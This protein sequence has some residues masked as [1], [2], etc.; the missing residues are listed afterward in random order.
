MKIN[1]DFFYPNNNHNNSNSRSSGKNTSSNMLRKQINKG[2]KF[3]NYLKINLL[4][5]TIPI[6]S[7]CT[8]YTWKFYRKTKKLIDDYLDSYIKRITKKLN[9]FRE[10]LEA[11]RIKNCNKNLSIELDFYSFIDINTCLEIVNLK[12][13]ISNRLVY[14]KNYELYTNK[15]QAIQGDVFEEYYCYFNEIKK[16]NRS[17]DSEVIRI[18]EEN[19]NIS[20]KKI[21]EKINDEKEFLLELNELIMAKDFYTREKYESEN[22]FSLYD[23]FNI[24]G[25][26]SLFSFLGFSKKKQQS[27]HDK[28]YLI[29][30][31][32]NDHNNNS[33]NNSNNN[34]NNTKKNE[35]VKIQSEIFD[36]QELLNISIDQPESNKF[37]I[38]QNQIGLYSSAFLS[39]SNVIINKLED[40]LNRND[41][42]LTAS[43]NVRKDL[44]NMTKCLLSN[45]VDLVKEK[46]N[47]NIKNIFA[48]VVQNDCFKNERVTYCFD[49]L[50]G[51]LLKFKICLLDC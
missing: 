35:N 11:E 43:I 6:V 49:E 22:K 4:I 34:S 31:N 8:L 33:Y 28:D 30:N 27:I 1:T 18:I 3:S 37:T 26:I 15:I 32:N 19:F 7:Y 25:F 45:A 50:I 16:K 21:E 47:L 44:R 36:P 20:Y 38:P 48:V 5:I 41:I 14:L 24:G 13:E 29:S 40:I 2:S 42:D 46:Y 39:F 51:Y 12:A 9:H 10:K 23:F 17:N